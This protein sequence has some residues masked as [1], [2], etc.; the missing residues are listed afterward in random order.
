M[1]TLPFLGN[2]RLSA[3][4][5]VPVTLY[6][7]P[8]SAK[9][10]DKARRLDSAEVE[11]GK[12]PTT[13]KPVDDFTTEEKAREQLD[14]LL[15]KLSGDYVSMPDS[16]AK[17]EKLKESRD[18]VQQWREAICVNM[19]AKRKL[20]DIEL[21]R[22]KDEIK[23]E[24]E[25]QLRILEA[26]QRPLSEVGSDPQS[27]GN[28]KDSSLLKP[29]N[30]NENKWEYVE[31]DRWRELNSAAEDIQKL[32]SDIAQR[33]ERL[34][35]A[36]SWRQSVAR[37]VNT[38]KKLR[39]YPQL[40]EM[41]EKIVDSVV[42][43][44]N[45]SAISSNQFYN[46]M[47]MGAAGTGKTRLAS[48]IAS[49]FAQLGMYVHERLVEAQAGDFI[50]QYLGETAAKSRKFL[51]RNME[52]VIFLDEA[53]ALT[54]YDAE[55]ESSN[56]G[57]RKL[58]QYSDEAVNVLIPHLSEN[59]GQ[60]AMIV[61]GY[62][63]RMK[64]DFLPANEGMGR[65]FPIRATLTNYK[66]E[67]LYKIFLK[68]AAV[69]F[70]GKRPAKEEDVV[71]YEGE[72]ER[73]RG[74]LAAMFTRDAEQLFYDVAS[75]SEIPKNDKLRRL[76]E[77]QA[78]AMTN[79][80]GV[81]SSLLLASGEK[82]LT[83]MVADRRAMFN[84]ILTFIQSVFT[85]FEGKTK[86]KE[87]DVARKELLDALR[88]KGWFAKK[89]GRD[90]WK[91]YP[92]VECATDKQGPNCAQPAEAFVADKF[93]TKDDFRAIVDDEDY[94]CAL[95]RIWEP[96]AQAPTVKNTPAK[97]ASGS[98]ASS[99]TDDT[100]ETL[101]VALAPETM[102]D[103]F[104][105]LDKDGNYKRTVEVN[106]LPAGYDDKVVPKFKFTLSGAHPFELTEAEQK[107][108]QERAYREKRSAIDAAV[109]AA[110]ARKKQ[111]L[112]DILIQQRLYNYLL[113][114][115]EAKAEQK[116]RELAK[117]KEAFLR[118]TLEQQ[119]KADKEAKKLKIDM[120]GA[121]EDV[122]ME[123][124][125]DNPTGTGAMRRQFLRERRESTMAKEAEAMSDDNE[126]APSLRRSGRNR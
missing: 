124:A 67:D 83:G 51:S 30:K 81:A 8:S 12:D 38:L 70:V 46:V 26:A 22:L 43:F 49:I 92:K 101:E 88:A 87:A 2:L 63:N 108:V 115:R 103:M 62:E 47:L 80:A 99:V 19:N 33:V 39:D 104:P 18:F 113:R 116:A 109:T 52:R 79:M 72:V 53:Y 31:K 16:Q 93:Y 66:K 69:S 118:E 23:N 94:A 117:R 96:P 84:I 14:A 1:S 123:S 78:G 125:E 85:G 98:S 95:E 100:I 27:Q 21:R 61:A 75:A 25:K 37:F 13:D 56:P 28:D 112:Q 15:S 121:D 111:L 4:T 29:L 122:D 35:K 24:H 6:E 36:D 114:K 74:V 77:A 120:V 3:P 5:G 34:R 32:Q 50:G 48:I 17:S 106:D 90:V 107:L 71:A 40:S 68:Q 54:H 41:T 57:E 44:V 126:E 110:K 119:T 59:V 102:K 11:G 55:A 64:A 60:M 45:N 20:Y 97:S 86:E 10:G 91:A 42:A 9:G 76:F 65:R 89:D 7:R 58:D 82:D 105:F 73:Q